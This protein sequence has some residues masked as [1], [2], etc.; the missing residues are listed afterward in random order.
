EENIGII[1]VEKFTPKVNEIVLSK[2]NALAKWP[3][4]EQMHHLRAPSNE[5]EHSK[6]L[7]INWMNLVLQ[8]K[9]V[10]KDI[11]NRLFGIKRNPKEYDVLLADYTIGKYRFRITDSSVNLLISVS[12]SVF[13][14]T[15]EDWEY[16]TA[17][18]IG[19]FLKQQERVNAFQQAYI[20]YLADFA[21]ID[22]TYPT[23]A[24]QERD[25]LSRYW[26][27]GSPRLWKNKDTIIFEFSK[28][29]DGEHPMDREFGLKQR[30]PCFEEQLANASVSE[31]T[32]LIVANTGPNDT[33]ARAKRSIAARLLRK[34][35]DRSNA[36]R[37][38]IDGY[39]E[40][41]W[42]EAKI[43]FYKH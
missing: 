6:P 10:P 3:D 1:T 29:R 15:V 24:Y 23:Q 14:N 4:Q 34:R 28:L 25:N 21:R 17:S 7:C 36:V 37:L 40:I 33:D 13:Q 8:K 38:L 2:Y 41:S 12:S 22:L 27:S 43:S 16:F 32:P 19:T 39:E 9:W 5:T 11:K 20:C 42:P 31:L 18:V 35:P 30:F 26:N